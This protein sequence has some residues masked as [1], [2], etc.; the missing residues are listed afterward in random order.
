MTLY[1]FFIFGF[2]GFPAK[3]SSNIFVY[4]F[5]LSLLN[6]FRVATAPSVSN[7]WKLIKQTTYIE[8]C[9]LWLLLVLVLN[10]THRCY[11]RLQVCT[12]IMYIIY[13]CIKRLNVSRTNPPSRRCGSSNNNNNSNNNTTKQIIIIIVIIILI[14]ILISGWRSGPPPGGT[15]GWDSW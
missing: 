15:W 13:V 1:F 6:G 14:L 10:I 7:W 9:L 11:V 4:G 3:T 5:R 2:M 8:I 12:R